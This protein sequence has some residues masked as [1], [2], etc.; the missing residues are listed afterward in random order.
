MFEPGP[1]RGLV[2]MSE[3]RPSF[4]STIT[5][6]VVMGL[7]RKRPSEPIRPGLNGA[8]RIAAVSEVV[9]KGSPRKMSSKGIAVSFSS[10]GYGL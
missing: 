3:R 1:P 2:W 4:S 9:L 5:D 8:L 10:F 6:V 7:S